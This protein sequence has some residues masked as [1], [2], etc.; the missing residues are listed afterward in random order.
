MVV[1][2]HIISWQTDTFFSQAGSTILDVAYGIKALPTN[3][4]FID[5]AE[6][7]MDSLAHAMKPG[8]FLVDT[9]P[10]LRYIPSWFPGARFQRFAKSSKILAD[11]M[12]E[13]PFA[14][15]KQ[16]IVSSQFLLEMPADYF[17]AAGSAGPCFSSRCLEAI[18][19]NQDVESQESVIKNTAAT[20]YIGN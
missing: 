10:I 7:G 18:D 14:A 5:A 3:D 12:V 6:R 2:R 1:P 20:M 13:R 8:A 17:Q 9:F 11:G 4:P 19:A 15:L 16:A